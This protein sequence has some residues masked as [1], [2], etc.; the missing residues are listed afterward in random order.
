MGFGLGAVAHDALDALA[1]GIYNTK[2]NWV[3]DADIRDFFGSL[4]RSW[5]KRFLEHRIA[6]RRVLRLIDKWLGAGIIEGG[7]WSQTETGTAQGAS[8]SSHCLSAAEGGVEQGAFGLWGQYS[9]A[10]SASVA[11]VEGLQLAALDTLQ[12][13]LAADAEGA[14]RVDD[15]DVAGGCVFDEQGAEL[16]VDADPPRSAWSVLFAGDE[17]GLQPAVECGGGDAEL[18]GGFA[19]GEQFAVGRLGRAA[20]GAGSSSGCGGWRRSGR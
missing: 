16:V 13:G 20:G 8:A 12:H 10:F 4:D 9:Q 5:L 19:D 17:S 2:V 1:A 15:R 6:D 18:V 3:L 11:D 7:V 14:H